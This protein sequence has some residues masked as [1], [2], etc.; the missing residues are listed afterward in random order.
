M[1]LQDTSNGDRGEINLSGMDSVTWSRISAGEKGQC[2]GIRGEGLCF[3]RTARDRAEGAQIVI[4]N[5]ALLLS[6]LAM[7]GGLIP[8]YQHLIIDEAHHLEDEATR[9]LGFQVSQNQL[10]E[11]LDSL[12]RILENVRARLRLS[13]L[14]S[15]EAQRAR[16]YVGPVGRGLVRSYAR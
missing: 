13:S 5:H 2:P 8:D 3:L 1:W 7:G 14:S 6:D 10:T 15:S 11:E 9:Q 12:G 16:K 4:V